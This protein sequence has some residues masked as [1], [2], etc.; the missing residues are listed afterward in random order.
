M[1]E[2][3]VLRESEFILESL[4]GIITNE[5]NALVK[6]DEDTLAEIVSQK[7][8]LLDSLNKHQNR[9]SR[10]L[11]AGTSKKTEKIRQLLTE[12]QELN[13]QNRQVGHMGLTVIN[14]SLDI[15]QTAMHIAPVKTYG[16]EGKNTGGSR[17]RRLVVV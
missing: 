8:H 17:K 16:P 4:L 15:L 5:Q 13:L 14:K 1:K 10:I 11:Q 9:L 6:V 7:N 12:C 2:Q 3:D